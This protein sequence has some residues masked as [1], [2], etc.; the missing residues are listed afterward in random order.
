MIYHT[1][2]NFSKPLSGY[3]FFKTP[4]PITG[5]VD[6]SLLKRHRLSYIRVVGLGHYPNKMQISIQKGN[7][8]PYLE[9]GFYTVKG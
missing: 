6:F 1:E 5:E 9:R 8:K 2:L 7:G 4:R 3:L